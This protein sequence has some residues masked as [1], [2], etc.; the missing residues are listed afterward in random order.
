[1][2][3]LSTPFG[4]SSSLVSADPSTVS[5]FSP[6]AAA[7]L[8][9]ILA[10]LWALFGIPE[11]RVRKVV[12][13]EDQRDGNRGF[14]TRVGTAII[15]PIKP[16]R[17]LLPQSREKGGSWNMMLLGSTAFVAVVGV[18]FLSSSA[19]RLTAKDFADMSL[20]SFVILSKRS[21]TPLWFSIFKIA[22]ASAHPPSV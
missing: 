21:P 22:F 17:L 7:A 12:A 16:L 4:R 14:W 8:V 13:V 15:S 5:P 19:N 20:V 11:T 10:A 6:Y 2:S 9:D 1:M 18:S 3:H